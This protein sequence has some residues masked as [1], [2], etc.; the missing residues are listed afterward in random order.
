MVETCLTTRLDNKQQNT[1]RY[2]SCVVDITYLSKDIY[3]RREIADSVH[4]TES[5]WMFQTDRNVQLFFC[6]YTTIWSILVGR[7]EC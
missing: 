5:S 3:L 4:S 6:G 2:L 1:T 7:S